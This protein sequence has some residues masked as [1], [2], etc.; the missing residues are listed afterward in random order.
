MAEGNNGGPT[1]TQRMRM[2]MTLTMWSSIECQ[3]KPT[4]LRFY[5]SFNVL[6]AGITIVNSSQ[7]HL[8]FDNCQGV[9]VHDVTIS[10]PE[11]S[12]NTDGIHLQ[13]S[14]DVSIHHT[15]MACALARRRNF[16]HKTIHMF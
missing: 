15:N 12:L 8:K 3:I 5:G 6:V 9:M 10:S 4:S 2:M 16:Q 11:N 14:K 13:N 1:Q 7:C